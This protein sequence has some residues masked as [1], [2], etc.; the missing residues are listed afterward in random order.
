MFICLGTRTALP[1]AQWRSVLPERGRWR[2]RA[3][4]RITGG[5]LGGRVLRVPRG[6]VRPTQDRVR[7]ALFSMLAN[8]V[9][10]S[11]F[12]DLFAGSGAVGLEAWSR[13]ADAVCWVE[14]DSRVLSVLRANVAA[15]CDGRADVIAVDAR[16][17]LERGPAAEPFDLIF[18]DPP[19]LATP[20]RGHREHAPARGAERTMDLD[21]LPVILEGVTRRGLLRADGFIVYEYRTGTRAEPGPGWRK[22]DERQYGE[23]GLS[24]FI[25]TSFLQKSGEDPRNT[26]EDAKS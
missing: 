26:R 24:L 10:G 8:R 3:R 22:V 14:S 6:D 7:L 2:I 13:G 15:L 16:R 23:T 1:D 11:R 20:E 21:W 4:V 25:Q 9:G 19:Y 12:L 18:A 5:V 17:F